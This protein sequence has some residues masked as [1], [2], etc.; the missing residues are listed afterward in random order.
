MCVGGWVGWGG[1]GMCCII[2]WWFLAGLI[3][4]IGGMGRFLRYLF[5]KNSILLACTP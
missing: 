1:G 3:L 2:W 4:G 5:S